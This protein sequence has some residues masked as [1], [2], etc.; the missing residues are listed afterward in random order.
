M[1]LELDTES[2]LDAW[3]DWRERTAAHRA[4]C[5]AAV[6]KPSD[7]G[8]A[9]SDGPGE[10]Q[11]ARQAE[12]G[13]L[14]VQGLEKSFAGRT[15]L[16]SVSFYV[17][18]DEVVTLLGPSDAGKTT[19]FHMVTGLVSADAGRIELDGRNITSLPMYQRARLGLAYVPQEPSIFG[20]LNVEQDIEAAAQVAESDN[21]RLACDVK[22]ILEEFDIAHLRKKLS[23]RL[24]DVERRRVEIARAIT[25]RP[26]YL[27]L[28][29]PFTNVE[30]AGVDD[31]LT[32][33]QHVS[34]RH[35]AVLIAQQLNQ[36]S[37]RA[38][39]VSDRAYVI[40]AGQILGTLTA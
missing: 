33:I 11:G 8:G 6:R 22:A 16:N 3:A 38:L 31:L 29:E 32:L 13:R 40:C 34:R 20:G 26:A 21:E 25:A 17:K 37:R 18:R 9:K 14:D 27:L 10:R 24:S 4:A 23:N 28:D 12:I 36:N 35:I 2:S 19:I 1:V 7:I 15:V 30:P 39:D 5:S